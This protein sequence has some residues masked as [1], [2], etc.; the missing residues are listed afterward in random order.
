M[1]R[2]FCIFEILPDDLF[3]YCLQYLS[4]DEIGRLDNSMVNHATRSCYLS[5]LKG[6]ER[7]ELPIPHF[8]HTSA[9][10]WLCS[11]GVRMKRISLI[12]LNPESLE[13]ISNCRFILQDLTFQSSRWNMNS[14]WD[15]IPHCPHLHRLNF[16]SCASLTEEGLVSILTQNSHLKILELANLTFLNSDFI[17]SLTETV[18]GL[19]H[20]SLQRNEQLTDDI[21]P[22]LLQLKNLKSI[23]LQRTDINDGTILGLMNAFPQIRF[24]AFSYHN[25]SS[26][27]V[28][29]YLRE[30]GVRGL[31]S[32]NL[33]DRLMAACQFYQTGDHGMI[34]L[35][36]FI[37]SCAIA[38]L[39]N[40]K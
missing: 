8:D 24:I 32:S 12:E 31:N 20:L 33:E 26:A 9:V 40:Y 16:N 22:S 13:L 11:R 6:F 37:L 21:L 39:S 18:S 14:L 36:L 27:T 30:M 5:S 38:L 23:N 4:L 28:I 1:K 2:I 25:M 17:S 19:N 34:C 15:Q 3:R 10:S 29:S 7:D 35:L